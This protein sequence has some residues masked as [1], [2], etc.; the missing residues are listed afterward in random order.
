MKRQLPRMAKA[1]MWTA[2]GMAALMEFDMMWDPVSGLALA[3]VFAAV[4]LGLRHGK[5]WSGY[6][7]A[8][9]VAVLATAGLLK[10]YDRGAGVWIG[11][12]LLLAVAAVWSPLAPWTVNVAP[13]SAHAPSVPWIARL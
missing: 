7:G 13:R 11:A 12:A 10:G 8:L 3:L 2:W 9:F 1:G 6:G 5:P 4:G